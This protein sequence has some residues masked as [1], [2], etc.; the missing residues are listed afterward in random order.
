MTR[1]FKNYMSIYKMLLE[2]KEQEQAKIM[3]D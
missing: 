2:A 3:L 1:K